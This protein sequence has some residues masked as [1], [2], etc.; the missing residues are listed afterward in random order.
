MF[1]HVIGSRLA[2]ILL[3]MTLLHSCGRSGDFH[4]EIA[5]ADEPEATEETATADSAGKLSD[6]QRLLLRQLELF[7]R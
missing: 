1:L 2:L 6:A 7:P 3:L 5:P 4:K